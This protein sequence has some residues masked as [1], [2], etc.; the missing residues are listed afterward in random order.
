MEC[1]GARR[2][3]GF[4]LIELLVVI[5][6]IALLAAILFPVFARA[7]ENARR[8]TC[9][10]NLKQLGLAVA[11]YSQDYDESYV[12]FCT[13][14]LGTWF[15]VQDTT[16][17]DLLWPELVFPYIK[18]S[19]I[20]ICPSDRWGSK[21][22]YMYNN[23][24]QNYGDFFN[25]RQANSLALTLNVP[26]G[27][28]SM[29][30]DNPWGDQ[31]SASLG[32]NICPS[33]ATSL[34]GTHT[35]FYNVNASASSLE[36]SVRHSAVQSPATKILMFDSTLLYSTTSTYANNNYGYIE[37]YCSRTD[38]PPMNINT[39][40]GDGTGTGVAN[41]WG[42]VSSRHFGGYNALF[43]DGHVKWRKYGSSVLSDWIIQL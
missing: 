35:G 41:T 9:Q 29:N 7:R 33:G 38:A 31:Y 34:S 27:S 23:A 10:S 42:R 8:S 1:N 39:I 14:Y 21:R 12:P 16:K 5:A 24:Y 15:G 28:Y 22:C 32:A 6:I 17:S 26:F 20:F 37:Y 40:E 19:Q 13:S 18:N 36:V 11:Q 4:T 30:A 2:K 3:A 25:G 43:A